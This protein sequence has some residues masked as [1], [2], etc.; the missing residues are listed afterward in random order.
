MQQSTTRTAEFRGTVGTS[1]GS[2]VGRSLDP[3]R[4]RL[5]GARRQGANEPIQHAPWR[6]LVRLEQFPTQLCVLRKWSFRHGCAFFVCGRPLP[7]TNA[8]KRKE[9]VTV[10]IPKNAQDI[11]CSSAC[12]PGKFMD[13]PATKPGRNAPHGSLACTWSTERETEYERDKKRNGGD[14]DYFCESALTLENT[15]RANCSLVCTSK[16]HTLCG[17]TI[18]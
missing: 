12:K 2:L 7:R 9:G 10:V 17:G 3:G 1:V 8:R 14:G 6:L 13:S 5:A 15:G 11:V 16:A 4:A 18:V